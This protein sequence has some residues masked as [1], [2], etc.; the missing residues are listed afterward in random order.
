MILELAFQHSPVSSSPP[1]PPKPPAEGDTHTAIDGGKY[2]PA[3]ANFFEEQNERIRNGTETDPGEQY[4]LHL[5][6][7]LLVSACVDRQVQ[8]PSYAQQAF[9]NTYGIQTVNESVFNGMNDAYYREGGCRDKINDCRAVSSVFDPE[10]V[11]INSTVNQ[12]CVD[13]ENFC[14]ENIRNPYVQLSGRSYYDITQIEPDP[15]PYSF[16]LGW[17]NEAV[18]SILTPTPKIFQC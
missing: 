16:Y 15:F 3:F 5:D 1:P 10:N 11:G 2:G 7:L 14:N 6:T 4:I 18:R 13:A 9:N 17:L 8:W 12:I